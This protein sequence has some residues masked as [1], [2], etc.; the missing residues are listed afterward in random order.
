MFTG[1]VEDVGTMLALAVTT[2]GWKLSVRTALP[3]DE[4]DSGDSIAVNGACLTVESRTPARGALVFHALQETVERTNLRR[5]SRGDPLNLERALRAGDRLGGHMVS[6]HVDQCVPVRSVQPVGR[7][8]SVTVELP[9]A[10]SEYVIEKGSVAI[11]GVSL[12]VAALD[13]DS[14]SV[15]LIPET[16]K[17][18][19]LRSL[20][21]G[22]PVNLEVD[23]VGKY[24]K[25]FTN[26]Q[27][28]PHARGTVTMSAL[29]QA[30]FE[31]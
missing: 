20:R 19:N 12:T 24:V 9:A 7:D 18:T 11:N 16:W 8:W 29:E 6:G 15:R 26:A 1:L 13:A 22:D 5:L 17:R 23:M 4:I 25:R 30:G 31:S 28:A 10:L 2:G 21:V 27:V 14:L 3:L